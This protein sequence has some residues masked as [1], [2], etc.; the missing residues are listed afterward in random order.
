MILGCLLWFLTKTFFFFFLENV[1]PGG[2]KSNLK[3][4]LKIGLKDCSSVVKALVS[5]IESQWFKPGL[6]QFFSPFSSPLPLHPISFLP[7][8][9]TTPLLCLP[10]SLIYLS[11]FFLC[12]WGGGGGGGGGKGF[13]FFSLSNSDASNV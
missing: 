6:G 4:P 1:I 2:G 5:K 7:S 11:L 12:V 13:V 9:L 3:L 8:F 10:Y